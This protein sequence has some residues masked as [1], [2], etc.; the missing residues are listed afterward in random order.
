MVLLNWSWKVL[1]CSLRECKRDSVS[2]MTVDMV[3]VLFRTN[4]ITNCVVTWWIYHSTHQVQHTSLLH[5]FSS[6]FSLSPSQ[7]PTRHCSGCCPQL[8]GT[9]VAVAQLVAGPE[10]CTQTQNGIFQNSYTRRISCHFISLPSDLPL[11]YLSWAG[12]RPFTAFLS[13]LLQGQ[14]FTTDP[15][16]TS[17]TGPFSFWASNN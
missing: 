6:D 2:S 17:P 9:P 11:S 8:F 3:M 5:L 7:D 10:P 14:C 13:L 1:I 12:D 16:C 4:S 15:T